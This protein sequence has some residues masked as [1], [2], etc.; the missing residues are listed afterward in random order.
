[1]VH[2]Y[3]AELYYLS[4][5]CSIT[6]LNKETV[7]GEVTAKW[8]KLEYDEAIEIISDFSCGGEE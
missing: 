7:T 4:I 8:A 5:T 2:L 1:M 6:E 3:D